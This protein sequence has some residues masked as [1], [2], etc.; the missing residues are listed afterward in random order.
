MKGLGTDLTTISVTLLVL[1]FVMVGIYK[2]WDIFE[3]ILEN[4]FNTDPDV[5][6]KAN[7]TLN[8]IPIGI[9]IILFGMIAFAGAMA[10]KSPA[11]PIF[12]PFS[13]IVWGIDI[14]GAHITKET[15]V[16]YVETMGMTDRLGILMYFAQN[17]DSIIAIAGFMIILLMYLFGR[18]NFVYSGG[19]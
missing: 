13:F 9:S 2:F 8:K 14:F 4:D 3:P 5:L 17:L 7:S 1:T 12:L 11:D 15:I 16:G 18:Q 6:D 10:Y 19:G